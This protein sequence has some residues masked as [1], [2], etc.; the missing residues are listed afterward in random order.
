LFLIHIL[1][2]SFLHYGAGCF[3]IEDDTAMAENDQDSVALRMYKNEHSPKHHKHQRL[4]YF[5]NLNP[6]GGYGGHLNISFKADSVFLMSSTPASA[7]YTHGGR[8]LILQ[9]VYKTNAF[10]LLI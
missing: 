3:V 2:I 10:V 4:Q 7:S 8:S 5:L 9:R 1:F 6:I